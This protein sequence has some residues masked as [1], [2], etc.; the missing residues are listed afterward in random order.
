MLSQ[1][2]V[3][4]RDCMGRQ[5]QFIDDLLLLMATVKDEQRKITAGSVNV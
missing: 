1:T 2:N 5:G 4:M 3:K